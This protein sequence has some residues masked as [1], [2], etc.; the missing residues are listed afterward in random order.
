MTPNELKQLIAS[1]SL[2]SQLAAAGRDVDC[3]ERCSAIAP[4]VRV[5]VANRDI[6]RHAIIN[7]YWSAVVRASEDMT[8]VNSDMRALSIDV[9][10]WIGDMGGTTDF[11]L[12]AVQQMLGGLVAY[13]LMTDAHRV[14]LLTLA[15]SPQTISAAE[16]SACF[17]S[18][19]MAARGES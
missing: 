11:A 4:P 3:A 7:R 10:G 2:A 9:A 13:G 16:V 5:P 8:S 1:D 18:E 17:E 12:P 15:D 19:R 6:K 14:S